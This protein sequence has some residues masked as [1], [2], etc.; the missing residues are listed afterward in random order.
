MMREGKIDE[1]CYNQQLKNKVI[2]PTMINITHFYAH[3]KAYNALKTSILD[4]ITLVQ[5]IDNLSALTICM[6]ETAINYSI[7]NDLVF[8]MFKDVKMHKL[9]KKPKTFSDQ[10]WVVYNMKPL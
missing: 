1:V 9:S 4:D 5:S 8:Y 7:V 2:Y 10:C 6:N 3:Y